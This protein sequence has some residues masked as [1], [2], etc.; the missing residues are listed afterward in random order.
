[1]AKLI[2]TFTL[3]LSLLFG[4][5]DIAPA[6]QPG[7]ASPEAGASHDWNLRADAREAVKRAKVPILLIHGED[8]HFVPC[9]MSREIAAANPEKIRFHTFPG[10]GHGLSYL[11]D[12]P[13][14]TGLIWDFTAE[15]L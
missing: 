1:M 3:I 12:E 8:D 15:I 9:D 5:F 13:R 14:Y 7:G 6:G 4:H 11:V 10:A 2:A